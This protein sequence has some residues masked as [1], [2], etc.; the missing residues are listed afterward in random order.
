VRALAFGQDHVD[1]IDVQIRGKEAGW[2]GTV[3]R[4][5]QARRPLL[6]V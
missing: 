1:G 5:V 3:T 4:R 2:H 6:W